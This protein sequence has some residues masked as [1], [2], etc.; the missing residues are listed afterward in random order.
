MLQQVT[1]GLRVEQVHIGVAGQASG[2]L[3]DRLGGMELADVGA[4][5]DN[6]VS[7]GDHSA[8]GQGQQIGVS[9]V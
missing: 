9:D 2:F 3:D 1:R 8:F 5:Q 7:L 6:Q 4:K